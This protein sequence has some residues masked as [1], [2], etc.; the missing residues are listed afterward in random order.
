MSLTKRE[1]EREREAK[2]AEEKQ[3]CGCCWNFD[4]KFEELCEKHA[5]EEAEA[6]SETW[7]Y[8]NE[9]WR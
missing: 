1:M 8:L 6:E 4:D 2:L 5:A 7:H 9:V 3:S